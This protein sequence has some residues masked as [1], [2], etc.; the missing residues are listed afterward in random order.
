[1]NNTNM[2]VEVTVATP[3][4]QGKPDEPGTVDVQYKHKIVQREH[5]GRH[6]CNICYI[7]PPWTIIMI[8]QANAFTMNRSVY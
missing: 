5:W 3:S 2:Y 8:M 6:T 4:N 7:C 1:M